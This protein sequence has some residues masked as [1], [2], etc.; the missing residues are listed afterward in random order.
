MTRVML[1]PLQTWPLNLIRELNGCNEDRLYATESYQVVSIY[2][3]AINRS[4]EPIEQTAVG[5]SCAT[6]THSLNLKFCFTLFY[7]CVLWGVL[8]DLNQVEFIELVKSSAF[9]L[10]WTIVVMSLKS[11]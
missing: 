4:R 11:L 2:F 9:L 5:K 3:N 7:L 6:A 1:S 8:L 10:L